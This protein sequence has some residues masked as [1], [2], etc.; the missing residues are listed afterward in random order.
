M[1][2]GEVTNKPVKIGE[3]CYIVGVTKR[4]DANMDDFAK[5]RSG[6]LEQMLKP[7]A[8]RRVPGLS[9]VRPDRNCESNGD[10]KIY[11][12]AVAKIDEQETRRRRRAVES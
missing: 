12:D 4:E 2:A 3:N 6:L 10:I 9:R 11:N 8:R 7:Q 1:K 5:K